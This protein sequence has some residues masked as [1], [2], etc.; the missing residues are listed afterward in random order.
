MTQSSTVEAAAGPLLTDAIHEVPRLLDFLYPHTAA[1][2][3]VNRAL[4]EYCHQQP[5]NISSWDGD[6]IC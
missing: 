2:Q 1:V 3:A 6:D 5:A 4:H